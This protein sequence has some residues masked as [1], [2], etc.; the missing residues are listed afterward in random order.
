MA[1]FLCK[2]SSLVRFN[3]VYV[4]EAHKLQAVHLAK[5]RWEKS[6]AER[7]AKEAADAQA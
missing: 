1:E 4:T 7:K 2:K 3:R 6:E 5:F